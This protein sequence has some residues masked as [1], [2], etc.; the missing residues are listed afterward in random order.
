MRT[1]LPLVL[2]AVLAVICG[3]GGPKMEPPKQPTPPPQ[4]DPF[5]APA[6]ASAPQ[7]PPAGR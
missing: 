3:C 6:K 1:L 4:G 5:A 2:S 7:P